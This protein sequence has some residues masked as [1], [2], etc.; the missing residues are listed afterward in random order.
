MQRLTAKKRSANVLS[1]TCSERKHAA[2]MLMHLKEFPERG[3]E[4]GVGC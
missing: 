2:S 4:G 3:H 1:R